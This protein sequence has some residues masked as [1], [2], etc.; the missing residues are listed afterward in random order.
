MTALTAEQRRAVGSKA[1]ALEVRAGAGT[2]KTTTLAHRL[3]RMVADGTPEHRLLAVTFTR[4][5]TAALTRKLGALLGK[6]H[7]VVVSSFHA[8]AARALA[9]DEPKF[10]AQEEARRIVLRALQRTPVPL[11]LSYALGA[12]GDDLATRALGFL[13]YVRNAETSVGG[14]IER[15]FPALAPWQGTMEAL[16]D[17][18]RTQKGDR[19]DYDDLLILFRDRLARG[20]AFRRRILERIDH[21]AVDEFQ[22]VNRAQAEIVRLVTTPRGA[23]SVTVVGDPRQSVYG[24]RGGAPAHF[25]AFRSHYGRRSELVA[26]T[27]SFRATRALVAAGNALLPDAHPLRPRPRAP[28]GSPALVVAFEDALAEARG[29]AD[30]LQGLVRAGAQPHDCVVLARS[31]ALAA[32]YAEEA[33]ERRLDVPIST[34]HAAKGLEWDHVVVLGAREG[35][36][37][38]A[39][40]LAAA[41][42][43]Q[44]ALLAEERRLLYVAATRARRSLLVTWPER[45]ERRAHLP[46]RFL[47]ALA[48]QPPA[49]G[50]FK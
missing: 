9:P 27:V 43:A 41:P 47:H 31:R 10:L 1:H 17:A 2:G 22:D 40:A 4:D 16:D 26:L 18:Y 23:P 30:H 45:G 7:G 38:S 5:A 13:S 34:I 29:V 50:S 42:A 36:L 14:A 39:Q 20:G 48:G 49:T 33:R 44:P 6:R 32:R 15:Q 28:P 19:L 37:P 8:W 12:G 11:G 35:G 3:A 24:F 21:L 46:S 25:D